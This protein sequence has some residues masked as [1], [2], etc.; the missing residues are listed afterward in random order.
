MGRKKDGTEARRLERRG[1]AADRLEARD[2]DACVKCRAR[3]GV[4]AR[5]W[6][7]DRG[8][9]RTRRQDTSRFVRLARPP[10]L[11]RRHSRSIQSSAS[12]TLSRVRPRWETGSLFGPSEAHKNPCKSPRNGVW[13]RAIKHD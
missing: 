13:A 4:Y 10:N 11:A 7:M 6:A 9:D 5:A 1:E 12:A 8:W 2:E 3:S